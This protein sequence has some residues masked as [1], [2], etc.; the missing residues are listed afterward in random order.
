MNAEE[1][2]PKEYRGKQY[3]TYEALQRQRRLETTLR[4]QRQEIKL[5]EQGHASEDDILA[6]KARYFKTSSEYAEFSKAMGLPQQ[7]ERVTVDGL[8]T[9][10]NTLKTSENIPSSSGGNSSETV[11]KSGES[12]IIKSN[13]GF[14]C[15]GDYLREVMGSA[16]DN[17]SAELQTMIDDV[18]A[19]GGKVELLPNNTKM[20]CNIFEGKPGTIEVDENISLGGFRH[21]YRHFLDDLKD[22]HK[23]I[24]F[25]LKDK[26]RFFEYERRGYE[27][28]IKTAEEFGC[29]EIVD[30]IRKQ[31][32]KRRRE[33]YGDGNN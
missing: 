27:E 17:N 28:E 30:K 19:K 20:V 5:L 8:G 31:I 7:R 4:A 24:G 6:A 32:E 16:K 1:N 13:E 14:K 26:D 25:Y 18:V 29:F 23:G 15:E 3:T 9:I 12:D 33:I 21:E 11:E 22:G 2:T 10:K